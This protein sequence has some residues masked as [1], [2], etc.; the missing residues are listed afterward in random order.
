MSGFFLHT[1]LII[2]VVLNFLG[3]MPLCE[4]FIKLQRV[5]ISIV[6]DPKA[7]FVR[8]LFTGD[9]CFKRGDLGDGVFH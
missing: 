4:F 3:L 9:D 7:V 8:G 6:I 5:L 2:I 1:N